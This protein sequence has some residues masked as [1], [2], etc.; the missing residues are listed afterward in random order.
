[1]G[2]GCFRLALRLLLIG[3]GLDPAGATLADC[4]TEL[5]A[6]FCHDASANIPWATAAACLSSTSDCMAQADG[7]SACVAFAIPGASVSTDTDGCQAAGLGRCVVYIGTEAP[8]Q[9]SGDAGYT[10][11]AN[12]CAPPP[13]PPSPPAPPMPPPM[14]PF[15]ASGVWVV[16]GN[17]DG[18]GGCVTSSSATTFD[19]LEVATQCCDGDTCKRY[20]DFFGH[21]A[22]CY[23][24]DYGTSSFVPRTFLEA[25]V[26]CASKGLTLCGISSDTAWGSCDVWNQDLCDYDDTYAYRVGSQ[27]G[28]HAVGIHS[29]QQGNPSRRLSREERG[30]GGGEGGGEGGGG[31]DGGG[32]GSG[33]RAVTALECGR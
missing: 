27:G 11:Y 30:G 25:Q 23:A 17:N 12:V 29:R 18:S 15:P 4:F 9:G 14:A 22:G 13:A 16:R 31:G 24:G 5:G 20:D 7:R 8:T 19:G 1:M 28:S 2:K 10:A 32:A 3:V 26:L 33:C 6:G 21:P